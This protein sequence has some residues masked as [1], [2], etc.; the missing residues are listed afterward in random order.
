VFGSFYLSGSYPFDLPVRLLV[1]SGYLP[2]CIPLV[3]TTSPTAYAVK[4]PDL[5]SR[6]RRFY[7][8]SDYYLTIVVP[9][10]IE[11][12]SCTTLVNSKPVSLL[13]VGISFV[14]MLHSDDSCMN[15]Q[16]YGARKS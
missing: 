4:E 5:K 7:A 15:A 13:P 12:N 2:F 10:S 9:C 1:F 11:F 16:S 8:H 14:V 3:E 6:G